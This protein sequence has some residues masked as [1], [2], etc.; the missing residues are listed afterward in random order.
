M[1]II[2]DQLVEGTEQFLGQ[3]IS[4]GGITYLY[5]FAPTATVDITDND[6][7]W[8]PISPPSLFITLIGILLHISLF[9]K[10]TVYNFELKFAIP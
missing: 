3:I 4:G 5:I 7:K 1:P 10:Q 9:L 2:N 6:S 8:I